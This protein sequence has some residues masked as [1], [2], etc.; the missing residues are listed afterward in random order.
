[1]RERKYRGTCEDQKVELL[2][3]LLKSDCC[4]KLRKTPRDCLNEDNF[5]KECT[6]ARHNFDRCRAEILDKRTRLRGKRFESD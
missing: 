1:M 2:L 3:C 5:P 4:Q 6:I